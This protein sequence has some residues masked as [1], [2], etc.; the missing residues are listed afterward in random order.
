MK[1]ILMILVGCS[2]IFTG[3]DNNKGPFSTK[4]KD[5]VCYLYSNDKLANGWVK[6]K[7][8]NTEIN[9]EV[10]FSEIYFKDGVP[11]GNFKLYDKKGK[12]IVNAEGKWYGAVFKGKIENYNSSGY[13][14]KFINE[15]SFKLD[16]ERLI[17]YGKNLNE[18]NEEIDKD[19]EIYMTNS[20]E[21][22]VSEEYIDEKLVEKNNIVNGLREGEGKGYSNGKVVE[23]AKYEHG[24]R[25]EYK[26][27]TED[28]KLKEEGYRKR[29]ENR[30]DIELE[31]IK[32][33]YE[34]GNLES[35]YRYMITE[36]D[37][38]GIGVGKSYYENGNIKAEAYIG[39]DNHIIY[40]DY[41]ENGNIKSE[42][43][44]IPDDL[45]DRYDGYCREYN[46]DGSLRKEEKYIDGTLVEKTEF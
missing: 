19:L 31:Y 45:I 9:K 2:L 41:Y 33:Y 29:S 26:I 16:R 42:T 28:G 43:R 35:D 23:V 4:E 32:K 5:G 3:C 14:Q 38:L 36:K 22:G 1:K 24:I 37:E 17:N 25:K 30:Y 34:N 44:A 46:E 10:M 7:Y 15:G 39:D 13:N 8:F 27:Y 6:K 40:K 11:G 21:T 18:E 20:L 12:I